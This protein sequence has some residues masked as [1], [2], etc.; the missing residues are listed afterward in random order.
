MSQP[1][2]VL[3][4]GA[5]ILAA[6]A[7]TRM[8]RPK[9][10]LTLGGKPL[11]VRTVEAAL[12]AG[13]WPVVVVVGARADEVVPL[14]ARHPVLVTD[15]AGWPE[16]MASSVRAGM[17]ELER[18]SR[19]LEAALLAVCDQPAFAADVIARLLAARRATG[20]SIAAARYGGRNG[21][22]ALF[23]RE[24]F[25]ALGAVTGEAGARGLLNEHPERV[26]AVELPE[27]EADLDTPEDYARWN[28]SLAK[29][30]SVP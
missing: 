1:P 27:L 30:N 7:S 20:R 22:P 25:A 9:Q 19:A 24:H 2:P 26:A 5:I 14:L 6:G 13:A 23:G 3:R 4:F 11:V 17:G 10:A 16:G 29:A 18:F 28:K 15:N 21:V 8:G 12:D